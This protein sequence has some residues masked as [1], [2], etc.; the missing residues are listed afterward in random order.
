MPRS[1][2]KQADSDRLKSV[3]TVY[4]HLWHLVIDCAHCPLKGIKGGQKLQ[5]QTSTEQNGID[6]PYSQQPR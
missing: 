3:K 5:A 1:G 4:G 2:Q 6:V